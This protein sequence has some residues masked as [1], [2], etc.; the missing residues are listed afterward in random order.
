M[1]FRNLYGAG[2]PGD[3]YGGNLK[4]VF[5]KIPIFST[6]CQAGFYSCILA[7]LGVY[8]VFVIGIKKMVLILS[9]EFG[10]WLTVLFKSGYY[11][12]LLC[13][14]YIY[15]TAILFQANVS[16]EKKTLKII[17]VE[18]YKCLEMK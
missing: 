4:M 6:L 12:S 15:S 7:F 1:D 10:M 9:A 13:T 3:G 2:S 17:C 11:V 8:A 5:S 14:I 18:K 16:F